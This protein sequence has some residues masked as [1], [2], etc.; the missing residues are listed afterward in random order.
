MLRIL[1]QVKLFKEKELKSEVFESYTK[2]FI[3]SF[4]LS[5]I[6]IIEKQNLAN[7]FFKLDNVNQY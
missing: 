3:R 5:C 4:R 1:F 7:E 2:S 6:Y